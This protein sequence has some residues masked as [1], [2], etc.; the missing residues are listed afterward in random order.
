ML[1]T[2]DNDIDYKVWSGV[3]G[4]DSKYS[5]QESYLYIECFF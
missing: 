4:I 3:E 2:L 5:P 1:T